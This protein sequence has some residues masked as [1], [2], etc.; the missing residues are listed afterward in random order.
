MICRT[1]ICVLA[2]LV[3]VALPVAAADSPVSAS[4]AE[5]AAGAEQLMTPLCPD[6]GG[7]A[8]SLDEGW[9]PATCGTCGTYCTSD[10]AC[11]GRLLG[12]KCMNTANNIEGYCKARTG[13]ALYNCCYCG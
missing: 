9:D 8:V 12:D 7:E 11:M 4:S 6:S 5:T 1:M 2:G 3:L 10:N 13:C